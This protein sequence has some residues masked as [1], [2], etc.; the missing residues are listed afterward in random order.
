MSASKFMS[1]YGLSTNY[2]FVSE[3]FMYIPLTWRLGISSIEALKIRI[4]SWVPKNDRSGQA[5]FY[6]DVKTKDEALDILKRFNDFNFLELENEF[7]TLFLNERI[8][9]KCTG[10]TREFLKKI[11][12]ILREKYSNLL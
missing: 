11:I 6:Y 3:K 12:P 10:D 2:S 7:E 4:S 8:N 5:I 1:T 9:L